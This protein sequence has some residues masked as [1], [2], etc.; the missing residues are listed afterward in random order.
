MLILLVVL[1]GLMAGIYF[2]FSTFIMKALNQLPSLQAAQAMN[3]INDIIVNTIFLP[4]FFGSTL[5]YA[6]MIVWA[7]AD[8]QSG[9]SL[10]VII[11]GLTYILGMFV[12]TAF[13]NVP[14]NNK[15]KASASSDS[16]LKEYWKVYLRA[17][18]QLN[19]LRTLSC[20]TSCAVLTTVLT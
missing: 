3:K 17:W 20:I 18:I 4:I 1:T 12:V 9:R 6:G 5:W 8:W 15:L 7:L 14:L 16:S 2:A 13:G 10:L 11:A 19:Y